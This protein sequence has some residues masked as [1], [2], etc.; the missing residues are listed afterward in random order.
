[1]GASVGIATCP[2][3][4]LVKDDLLRV[5]DARLYEAKPPR[6]ERRAPDDSG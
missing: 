5:A 1:M 6:G 4:G 2:G 3:D